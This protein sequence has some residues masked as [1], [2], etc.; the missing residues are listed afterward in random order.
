MNTKESLIQLKKSCKGYTECHICTNRRECNLV[1]DI[2]T[3]VKDFYDRIVKTPKYWHSG[4]IDLI[5]KY[6]DTGKN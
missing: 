4:N 6:I 2:I 3:N 5:A 1:R